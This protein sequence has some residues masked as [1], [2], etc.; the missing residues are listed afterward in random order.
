MRGAEDLETYSL[1]ARRG[2]VMLEIAQKVLDLEPYGGWPFFHPEHCSRL[3]P[4]AREDIRESPRPQALSRRG[5]RAKDRWSPR[6]VYVL[7]LNPLYTI[8][9]DAPVFLGKAE[10]D[11]C[12][13]LIELD[14]IEFD[15]TGVAARS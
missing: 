14:L 8:G 2:N 7:W 11:D 3:V 12:A 4:E 15:L 5:R 13:D 10:S 1:D 6:D 9:G